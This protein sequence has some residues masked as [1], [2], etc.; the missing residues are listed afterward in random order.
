MSFS[1][2]YQ[3]PGHTGVRPLVYKLQEL[4]LK[5]FCA[6]WWCLRTRIVY[7]GIHI[8][9]SQSEPMTW[10][11]FVEVTSH[12]T[13]L[14]PATNISPQFVS[15][16]HTIQNTIMSY[17]RRVDPLLSTG[18]S[19]YQTHSPTPAPNPLPVFSDTNEYVH[20]QNGRMEQG[21]WRA[22]WEVKQRSTARW[23]RG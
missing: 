13:V 5:P 12:I 7:W 14:Q 21:E 19:S 15:G 11:A 20:I 16:H 22:V 6:A 17:R 9:Q 3:W 4:N 23:W 10:V 18:G 8:H 1:P 2:Q